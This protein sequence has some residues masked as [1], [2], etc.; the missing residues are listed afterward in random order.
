MTT[1]TAGRDRARIRPPAWLWA[2]MGHEALVMAAILL[3]VAR[4]P[5]HYL[6]QQMA[7]WPAAHFLFQW[8]SLWFQA[9]ARHGYLVPGEGLRATVFFPLLPL[10]IR[11]AGPILGLLVQQGALL[12]VFW[13]LYRVLARFDL[14]GT[15]RVRALWLFAVNPAAIFY[16]TFYAETWMLLAVL[17]SLE[18]AFDRQYAKAA[19]VG[20]FGSLTE[21]PAVLLG[22]IPLVLVI[23]RFW[24]GTRR[25]WMGFALWGIGIGAGVAAFALYLGVAFGHPLLFTTEQHAAYWHGRLGAPWSG[26]LAAFL[27]RGRIAL[28]RDP[29]GTLVVFVGASVMLAGASRAAV[30]LFRRREDWAVALGLYTVAMV[31]LAFGFGTKGALYHSTL[32]FLSPLF[33]VYMG[34]SDRTATWLY[35][36]IAIVFVALALGGG[37]LFAHGWF[38][39]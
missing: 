35:R 20:F 24:T 13:L 10:I 1:A 6:R 14:L 8:D 17:A 31:W 15:G 39:Q 21:G 19:V 25:D 3:P 37:A 34:L 28:A 9:I 23:W 4:P 18:L 16:S 27:P 32:R 38:Y 2:F 30:Q 26:W 7:F 5:L 29:G 33:P 11:G 22:V 12:A 36:V